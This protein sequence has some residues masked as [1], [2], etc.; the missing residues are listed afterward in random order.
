MKILHA[1]FNIAGQASIISRAQRQIGHQSDVLI[2]YDNNFG[3]ENDFDLKTK[4]TNKW[5]IKFV[6]L[7]YFIKAVSQYDILHFHSGHGLL[8]R[9]LD[10]Y[11]YT[12]LK[13]KTVMHYW[14]SD[15]IQSDI[16]KKYTLFTDEIFK[17]VYP[18]LNNEK[19]RAQLRW[20][21]SK[22]D[23]TIV[24]DFSLLPYSPTSIV[25]RQAINLKKIKDIRPQTKKNTPLKILHAPTKKDLKGT[26]II[27]SIVAKL[28]TKYKIS[29]ERIENLPN[30]QA[31]Q[32]YAEAD[33]IVD[34]ILQG[35]Y[36][37]LAI[38]CMA[39]QKPVICRIDD[40]LM[41]YYPDLPIVNSNPDTLLR[42]LETLITNEPLRRTLGK[43]G[44]E[45]VLRHHDSIKIAQELVDL[46]ERL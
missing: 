6:F 9:L 3:Y 12:I 33:I 30:Q 19:K 46:Y 23:A 8:P 29:Y 16:A 32:K 18:T 34:D 1:P 15:V 38:E 14:G 41:H 10:F 28:K 43:K 35:P 13:K 45:Y 37:I 24:G 17:K 11:C 42:N 39:L 25:I 2:F 7:F 26:S 4:T 36:G 44:R 20:M 27:E 22:V 40:G 21:E 5:K 31:L